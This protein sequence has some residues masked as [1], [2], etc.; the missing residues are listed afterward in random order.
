MM[1]EVMCWFLF[2]AVCCC[3]LLFY[4]HFVALCCYYYPPFRAS[5]SIAAGSNLCIGQP[6]PH[7]FQACQTPNGRCEW[8]IL[9]GDCEWNAS[10]ILGETV[11]SH[12]FFPSP[13]C[14]TK[15]YMGWWLYSFTMMLFPSSSISHEEAVGQHPRLHT[16][17]RLSRRRSH[18]S[19][20]SLQFL[21]LEKTC[22]GA[23]PT[24]LQLQLAAWI[25]ISD[26]NSLPFLDH[27]WMQKN[28]SQQRQGEVGPPAAV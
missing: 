7:V 5:C 15:L 26:L 28:K 13:R 8:S 19:P 25:L 27:F 2:S 12:L 6:P 16:A 18:C 17:H 11:S 21:G 20:A 9:A 14:Y 3:L 24:H 23:G 4:S 1:F 10:R 22:F